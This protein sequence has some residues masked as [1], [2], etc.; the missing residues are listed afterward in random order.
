MANDDFPSPTEW[1]EKVLARL[2]VDLAS[3][4]LWQKFTEEPPAPVRMTKESLLREIRMDAASRFLATKGAFIPLNNPEAGLD[5]L[6]FARVLKQQIGETWYDYIKDRPLKEDDGDETPPVTITERNI[7]DI[8]AAVEVSR[9]FDPRMQVGDWSGKMYPAPGNPS[10]RLFRNGLWD[11]NTWVEPAYRREATTKPSLGAFQS[12]LDFCLPREL[13]QGV[14]LDWLAWSLQ[15]EARRPNWAIF[16]FSEEKGT[17][18]STILD[19]A[20]ALFGEENTARENGLDKLISRFALESLNK[21][22]ITVEEVQITSFSKEGNRL[23]EFITGKQVS[24][25]VKY[26]AAQ[27]LP[28][29]ACFMLTTNHRPIWLE[30][31]ERRYYIIHLT[32]EGHAQGSESEQF[33]PL[34]GEVY[35]QINDPVS[36]KSLHDA[37][38]ERELPSDFNPNGLPFAKYASPIMKDL[39]EEA[40]V[41]S[42]EVL[43][44][45]LQKYQCVIIPSSEQKLLERHQGLKPQQLRNQL[46]R[47]GWKPEKVFFGKAQHRV[48]LK[49]NIKREGRAMLCCPELSERLP[50][51][52]EKGFVWWPVATALLGWNNLRDTVLVPYNNSL[53]ESSPFESQVSDT[54]EEGPFLDSS[55]SVRFWATPA[56]QVFNSGADPTWIQF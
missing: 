8:I 16:L 37:L 28:M 35:K 31:G 18:K 49:S 51:A 55:K 54:G 45:L 34:V 43:E 7:N 19:V 56:A 17:G 15:N 26:Q 11:I 21:K 41:E 4:V 10:K 23:K 24:V 32:H 13:E 48:W 1:Q 29:T 27:T 14:L 33:K 3:G 6:S 47:L 36:L 5:A 25:D 30:G 50:Q 42:D 9:D 40:V 53:E 46:I 2:T 22:L 52:V 20:R 12:F 39:L 38:L 44:D